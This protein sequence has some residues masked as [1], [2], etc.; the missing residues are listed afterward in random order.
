MKMA[1]STTRRR[2]HSAEFKTKVVLAALREDQTQ[3]QLASELGIHPM[4]ITQ[5]KKVGLESLPEIFAAQR[6]RTGLGPQM[7][8]INT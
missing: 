1:R 2:R 8:V 7:P 5:W 4:P 6:A 3:S